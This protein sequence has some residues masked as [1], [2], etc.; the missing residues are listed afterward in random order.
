MTTL[1]TTSDIPTTYDWG[2]ATCTNHYE[3]LN[4]KFNMSPNYV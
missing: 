4:S 1:L 3:L 2:R